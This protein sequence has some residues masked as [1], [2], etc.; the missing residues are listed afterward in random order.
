VIKSY[1]KLSETTK[2]MTGYHEIPPEEV[3]NNISQVF[4][5]SSIRMN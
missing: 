4:I 5:I 1:S 3:P 2:R